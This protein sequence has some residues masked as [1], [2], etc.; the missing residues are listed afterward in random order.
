MISVDD[1]LL[2]RRAPEPEN[3]SD[4]DEEVFCNESSLEDQI[5]RWSRF[6]HGQEMSLDRQ[7][8]FSGCEV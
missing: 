2:G 7:A 1:Y 4:S 6:A 5:T 8:F 3:E